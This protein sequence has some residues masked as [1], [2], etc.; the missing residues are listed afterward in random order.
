MRRW[1]FLLFLLSSCARQS[2]NS[3][4]QKSKALFD[5]GELKPALAQAEEGLRREPSWRFRLLKAEILLSNGDASGATEILRSPDS[6]DSDE[7]RAR[8]AMDR[9]QARY[10]L[11][12]YAG[13]EADLNQARG[14]AMPLHQPLLDAQ[15]ELR[16][17]VL[18]VRS[19][20]GALAEEAFRK[21][22]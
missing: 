5:R 18:L 19:G 14:L 21:V 1:A 3:I 17:G 8:L 9:G 22:F 13:A 2:P 16:A 20:K 4:Y 12:D 7:L 11:S 10:L 6:P 15:I